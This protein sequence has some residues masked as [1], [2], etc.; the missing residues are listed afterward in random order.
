MVIDSET[1][2][3]YLAESLR[4]KKYS[5]FFKLLEKALKENSIIPQFL[6]KTKDI[7][8]VD[9]M[10]IQIAKEKFIQFDY[11][12]DYLYW[13]DLESTKT[14]PNIIPETLLF[15]KNKSFLKVDGGNVIRG[16]NKVI[17]CDKVLKENINCKTS[18]TKI[19]NELLN[20]FQV[21]ELIFIPTHSDDFV[22]HADGMIRFIDDDHVIINDLTNEDKKFKKDL[23]SVLKEHKLNY[24][25]IPFHIQDSKNVWDAR[26]IY[27]NYLQM[28]DIIFV[29]QFGFKQDELANKFLSTTFPKSKIVPLLCN[30]I[31]KEGGVLNCISWN[32]LK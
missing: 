12:P 24:S 27:I 22:G 16:K 11:D 20:N 15:S 7:W 31:A 4:K 2:E 23:I 32:I 25:E 26:G 30:E 1:N 19:I 3:L 21:E 8:A 13:F 29:P 28:K 6:H 9:F 5:G 18:Q 10:P 17:M 14:Y